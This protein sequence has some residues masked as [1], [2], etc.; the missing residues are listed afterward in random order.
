MKFITKRALNN[1]SDLKVCHV[2]GMLTFSQHS[3]II[4]QGIVI[5][6]KNVLEQTV[7]TQGRQLHAS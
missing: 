1:H 3:K 2:I 6:V 4:Y 5:M 7:P